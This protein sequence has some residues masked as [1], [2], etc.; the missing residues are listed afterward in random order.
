MALVLLFLLTAAMPGIAMADN[1]NGARGA[2]FVFCSIPVAVLGFVI[3]L[4]FLIKGA[5]RKP[6]FFM[7]HSAVFICAAFA[8]LIASTVG[9]DRQ[10]FIIA[11]LGES[12]LLLIVL[13]PGFIQ[14][15]SRD[16]TTKTK[17]QNRHHQIKPDRHFMHGKT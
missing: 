16:R 8:V 12:V 6:V 10:S 15:L 17:L 2:I 11:L 14:Y 7:I 1:W 5:F 13:L 4:A 9:G 3:S